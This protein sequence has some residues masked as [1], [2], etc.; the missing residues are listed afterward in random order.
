MSPL[1]LLQWR[2]E[3]E[4]FFKKLDIDSDGVVDWVRDMHNQPLACVT[5]G[6]LNYVTCCIV[7]STCGAIV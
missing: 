4:T 6:T 2:Y 5:I 3:L 7:Q 1:V